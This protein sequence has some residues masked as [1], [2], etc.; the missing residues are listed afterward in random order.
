MSYELK[1]TLL[2]SAA[3]S[4]A[5]SQLKKAGG[6]FMASLGGTSDDLERDGQVGLNLR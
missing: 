3:S 6:K 4:M 1:T 5:S 2:T